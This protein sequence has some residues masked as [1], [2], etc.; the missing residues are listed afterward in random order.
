MNLIYF[1]NE[2]IRIYE[3]NV[4]YVVFFV[5]LEIYYIFLLCQ[6]NFIDNFIKVKVDIC[7]GFLDFLIQ[8][9]FLMLIK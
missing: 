1:R 9:Y 6:N 5:Y 8:K 4:F 3:F 2:K 7:G